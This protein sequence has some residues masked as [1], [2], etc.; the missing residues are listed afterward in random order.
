M[1]SASRVGVCRGAGTAAEDEQE[2][3]VM[4]VR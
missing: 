2:A 4:A 3:V 1:N